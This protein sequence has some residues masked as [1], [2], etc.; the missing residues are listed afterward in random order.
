MPE[1][2]TDSA[3]KE[4]NQ[5]SHG[6][7]G[8]RF[9]VKPYE[10]HDKL[11]K[12]GSLNSFYDCILRNAII[13]EDWDTKTAWVC[14]RFQT[15]PRQLAKWTR[16][17]RSYSGIL[18]KRLIKAKII[19][20]ASDGS[21]EL[22]MYKKKQDEGIKASDIQQLN[23]KVEALALI[24]KE[25]VANGKVPIPAGSGKSAEEKKDKSIK[26][27][28]EKVISMFYKGI[29]QP[30]ISGSKRDKARGVYRKLTDDDFTPEEIHFAVKWTLE[31]ATEQPY[32]FAILPA[33]IGQALAARE[34]VESQ[35][36]NAEER[37]EAVDTERD[38]IEEQE[39]ES[40]SWEFYKAEL[41]QEEREELRERATKELTD[42][43]QYAAGFI[44][45]VLIGI[46][47]NEIL[48]RQF[49]EGNPIHEKARSGD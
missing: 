18:M 9:Y 38:E 11:A 14:G 25:V 31:N 40:D 27:S 41:P 42:S 46:K 8:G 3:T 1:I 13:S 4:K 39:R 44:N 17:S 24:V 5:G 36:K 30:R 43:K 45:D 35:R 28:R 33:M 6:R 48:R 20:I 34:S 22:P 15:T 49:P 26:L 7:M 10:V 47:E 21:Y 32:D 16:R 23:K 2:I 37:Q 12:M 29:G 19:L